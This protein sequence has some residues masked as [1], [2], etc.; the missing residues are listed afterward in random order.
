[1]VIDDFDI[2][3]SSFIP[4]KAD[5]PLIV[6]PDRILSNAVASQRLKAISRRNTQISDGPGLVEQTKLP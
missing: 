1:M 4:D 6:D 5:S 2:R 3:R